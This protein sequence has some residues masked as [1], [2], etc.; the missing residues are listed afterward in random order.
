M[1]TRHVVE[2]APTKV[3]LDA[4]KKH[5]GDWSVYEKEFLELMERRHIETSVARD[6]IDQGCLLCSVAQKPMSQPSFGQ[7]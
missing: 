1:A 5:K 6:I 7:M 4:Y 3:L 2:L